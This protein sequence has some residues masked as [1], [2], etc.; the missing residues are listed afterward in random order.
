MNVKNNIHNKIKSLIVLNKERALL[1]TILFIGAII[2]CSMRKEIQQQTKWKAPEWAD[3]LKA[4]FR[5]INIAADKGK[6]LFDNIC[7]LCHG[8]LG[9]GDGIG[10]VNLKPKPKD[11]SSPTVQTQSNGAIFWKI[12]TGNVPMASYKEQLTAEQRWQL[13][14][15]IRKLK[16]IVK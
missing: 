11:L 4:N 16:S 12:T 13:V 3:T 1:K 14:Y 7:S 8:K 2:F 6:I 15:Y 9:K 5:N 10:G